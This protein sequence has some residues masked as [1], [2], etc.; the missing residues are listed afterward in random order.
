MTARRTPLSVASRLDNPNASL[1]AVDVALNEVYAGGPNATK[2]SAV[3]GGTSPQRIGNAGYPVNSLSVD[4][5]SDVVYAVADS[6]AGG[7]QQEAFITMTPDPVT[8]VL[9]TSI[10]TFPADEVIVQPAFIANSIAADPLT[11]SLIASGA[12]S[13][14]TGFAQR[15]RCL[16]HFPVHPNFIT[17]PVLYT[18]PP[19]TTSLDMPNR[20]FYV[21]D[22][23]GL[24]SDPSSHAAMVTGI[25]GVAAENNTLR[26]VTIPVFG[27]GATPASPHIYRCRTGHRELPGMDLGV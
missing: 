5:A 10:T 23:D 9:T 20:A 21:T 12:A 16:R 26:S 4:A 6:G 1:L 27:S 24:L 15:L 7:A 22:F 25:D 19:L 13:I 3:R 18:W 17:A 14:N 2:V 8:G 11:G